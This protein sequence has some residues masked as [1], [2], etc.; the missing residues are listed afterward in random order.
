MANTNQK[1]E[2]DLD[3]VI[4]TMAIE[5]IV[6]TDEQIANC[7]AILSDEID[8]EELVKQLFE[9]YRANASIT[10]NNREAG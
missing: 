8:G 2:S 10:D 6:L 9:K 5:G 1:V 7:R 4:S 3:S